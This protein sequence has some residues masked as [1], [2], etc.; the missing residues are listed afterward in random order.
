M[1][2]LGKHSLPWVDMRED[3]LVYDNGAKME[4]DGNRWGVEF[5]VMFRWFC[6]LFPVPLKLGF[7][8]KNL[9]QDDLCED[10]QELH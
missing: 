2:S 6:C 3:G 8:L 5:C 9:T 4:R 10:T 1:D 7:L